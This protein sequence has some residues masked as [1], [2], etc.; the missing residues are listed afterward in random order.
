MTDNADTALRHV[1]ALRELDELTRLR[2]ENERLQN[3][4]T[5]LLEDAGYKLWEPKWVYN[6][7]EKTLFMIACENGE[8]DAAK[9]LA[10][11][12]GASVHWIALGGNNAYAYTKDALDQLEDDDDDCLANEVDEDY[13]VNM[14]P[15]LRNVL[16]YLEQLGLNTRPIRPDSPSQPGFQEEFATDSESEEDEEDDE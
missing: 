11:L 5:F 13:R 4:H 8:L 16:T 6:H 12:P 3:V 2:A 1:L 7:V 14:I 15:R 10:S 9:F